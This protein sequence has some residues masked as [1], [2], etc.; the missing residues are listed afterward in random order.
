MYVPFGVCWK[1]LRILVPFPFAGCGNGF[2]P[3]KSFCFFKDF[4]K[5]RTN[6]V[7]QQIDAF[8]KGAGVGLD[9]LASAKKNGWGWGG[10]MGGC[11]LMTM[12]RMRC[13]FLTKK[14]MSIV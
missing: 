12:V 11:K 3:R 6:A 7:R 10:A 4:L 8:L 2:I 9:G 1:I 5:L 13:V 14:E